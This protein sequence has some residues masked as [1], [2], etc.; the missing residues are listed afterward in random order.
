[1][2]FH[3]LLAAAGLILAACV[4]A[5][6]PSPAADAPPVAPV[7]DVIDEYWG[8]KIADPYRYMENHKDPQVQA[9]I[10][11]QADFTARSWRPGARIASSTSTGVPMAGSSTRRS[12]PT[13]ISPASSRALRSRRKR[14]CWWT[15]L[16]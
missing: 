10:K 8:Q 12:R 4:A 9:W 16:P 5:P 1:M 3:R 6:H 13:R 14:S 7:R 15:P 11:G 2:R